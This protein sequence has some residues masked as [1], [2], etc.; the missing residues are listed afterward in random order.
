M[1][2]AIDVGNTHITIGVF[3]GEDL[4]FNKRFSSDNKMTED[5][6]ASKLLYL[7]SIQGIKQQEI[8]NFIISS[9]VPNITLMLKRF[10]KNY[11]NMDPVVVDV[12]IKTDIV[13]KF[14]NPKEIGADRIVN[15]V[16]VDKYFGIPAIVVDFGTATTF[17]I[18]NAKR[19]YIGGIITPGI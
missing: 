15:A 13:L 3:R 4:I 1:L 7:L 17:D 16:A 8:N 10:S 6:F 9:V 11:L 12:E 2:L 14:D 18:I 19:E 5:E